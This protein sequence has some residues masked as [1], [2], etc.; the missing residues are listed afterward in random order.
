M[1]EEAYNIS[2]F[3]VPQPYDLSIAHSSEKLRVGCVI[4]N[5]LMAVSPTCR[6]AVLMAKEAL[7]KR[8]H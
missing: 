8:G 6:R 3:S 2:K 7:E 1:S 4:D 5:D